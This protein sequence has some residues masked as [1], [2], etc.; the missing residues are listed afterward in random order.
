VTAFL[1]DYKNASI[2]EEAAKFDESKSERS[3]R[4]RNVLML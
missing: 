1:V 2:K 4:G 3:D